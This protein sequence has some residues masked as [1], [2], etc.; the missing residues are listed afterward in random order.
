MAFE[1]LP[2]TRFRGCSAEGGGRVGG[3]L[4]GRVLSVNLREPSSGIDYFTVRPNA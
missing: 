4:S 1:Q 3:P 2:E